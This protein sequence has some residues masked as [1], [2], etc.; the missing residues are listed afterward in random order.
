MALSTF[1]TMA[2]IS[3]ITGLGCIL[4]LVIFI[5]NR[6]VNSATFHWARSQKLAAASAPGKVQTAP[7]GGQA[8][9]GPARHS[10]ILAPGNKTT[11]WDKGG[12]WHTYLC[13]WK[14][15]LLT[16]GLTALSKAGPS[17]GNTIT[18]LLSPRHSSVLVALPFLMKSK[19]NSSPP[20]I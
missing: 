8:G 16:G 14:S 10:D 2:P 17:T 9:R 15:T 11:I 19:T 5:N 18:T 20:K 1:I 6:M 7:L 13:C 3:E 4:L 12:E